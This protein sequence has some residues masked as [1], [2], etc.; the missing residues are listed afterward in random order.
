MTRRRTL[1]TVTTQCETRPVP[2]AVERTT[3]H[4]HVVT[5]TLPKRKIYFHKA[6]SDADPDFVL[7]RQ[8][9][10]E[11]IEALRD[12]SEFLHRRR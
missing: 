6:V 2:P 3:W 8:M 1:P 9:I 11:R 10:T 4:R 7:D 5:P 12:T